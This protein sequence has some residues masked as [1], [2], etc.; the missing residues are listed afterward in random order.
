MGLFSDFRV[1][2]KSE[3]S[4]AREGRREA[5]GKRA[6][7]GSWEAAVG[8]WLPWQRTTTQSQYW[9]RRQRYGCSGGESRKHHRQHPPPLPAPLGQSS[10]LFRSEG[11]HFGRTKQWV[12]SPILHSNSQSPKHFNAM[13][14][15]EKKYL[16]QWR[17]SVLHNREEHQ[18]DIGGGR[19]WRQKRKWKRGK[20]VQSHREPYST[21]QKAI[22]WRPHV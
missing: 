21:L 15:Y 19:G 7:V 12:I 10:E 11:N 14:G 9:E 18:C 16:F 17:Q 1:F 4:L 6:E 8:S 13:T 20:L 5:S 2:K 3:T 22:S